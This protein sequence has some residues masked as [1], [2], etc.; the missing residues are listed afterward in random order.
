MCHTFYSFLCVK[1]HLQDSRWA[2]KITWS[3]LPYLQFGGTGTWVPHWENP[4][5][6]DRSGLS[7]WT[8]FFSQEIMKTR[9]KWIQHGKMLRYISCS[10][11]WCFVSCG[12]AN[13]HQIQIAEILSREKCVAIKLDHK[14][15]VQNWDHQC[16]YFIGKLLEYKMYCNVMFK[17]YKLGT[18]VL[19]KSLTC[20]ASATRKDVRGKVEWVIP[21]KIHTPPTDGMIF[22]TPPPPGF[23]GPLDPPSC[24]DFQVQRP[25]LPPGF[26]L[27]SLEGL[28]LI[29]IQW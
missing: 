3:K 14:R 27:I 5:F 15:S 18:G 23:P 17:K 12:R 29:E 9:T 16:Q 1:G 19:S 7:N 8:L 22:F 24:P 10:F 6:V 11:S 4:G 13:N 25:P 21:E 2:A 20:I 28:I 26:P